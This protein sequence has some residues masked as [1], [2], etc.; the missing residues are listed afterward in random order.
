MHRALNYTL[1]ALLLIAAFLLLNRWLFGFQG[2]D[3]WVLLI[4]GA[5][6]LHWVGDVWRE[7]ATPPD[8]SDWYP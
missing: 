1:T 8:P 6:A 5:T 3:Q 4:A 7:A 2:I